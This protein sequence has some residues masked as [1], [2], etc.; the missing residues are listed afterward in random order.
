MTNTPAG[1][2]TLVVTMQLKPEREASF[3]EMA[4]G[5]VEWVHA[6]EPDTLLYT[7]NRHPSREH[8]YVGWNATATT[9]RLRRTGR[10]RRARRR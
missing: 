3:L 1:T 2:I 8:T 7:L 10:A 6:N 4:A 9:R 5:F